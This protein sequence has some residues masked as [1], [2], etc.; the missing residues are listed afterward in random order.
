MKTCL[1][2]D[3]SRVIRKVAR[4]ILEDLNFDIAEAGDGKEALD[5]LA[6]DAKQPDVIFLDI[7]MP[8]MD[9]HEFLK[10]FDKTGHDATIVVMLTSSDQA[11]D[12]AETEHY[13]YV[14]EHI[15][16][17]LREEHLEALNRIKV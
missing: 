13:D 3:D 8:R 6:S 4:R 11:R 15:S 12:K 16:K 1:V 10:E 7:N 14:L 17:P 2:V 9:G 5:L